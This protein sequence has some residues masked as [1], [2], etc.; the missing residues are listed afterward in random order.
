MYRAG[1]E[2]RWYVSL[3]C[4][5]TVLLLAGGVAALKEIRSR[6]AVQESAAREGMV[7]SVESL[8]LARMK[9]E[10]PQRRAAELD[11]IVAGP[12][13][14]TGAF[15][16]ERSHGIV[17][18]SGKV[19]PSWR[20]DF[21]KNVSWPQRG[22]H[23]A[24]PWRGLWG[25]VAWVSVGKGIVAGMALDEE[26]LNPE[27]AARIVLGFFVASGLLITI[28]VV[29]GGFF[30]L[31]HGRRMRELSEMKTDF[32]DSVTHELKTPLAGIR[33][34]I[35][36][37]SSPALKP[38]RAAVHRENIRR[39]TLRLIQLVDQ[40]LEVGRIEGK[41]RVYSPAPFDPVE[42]VRETVEPME[43]RFSANGI[44]VLDK[45]NARKMAWG[46]RDA[47]KAAFANILDNAAK[48][49]ASYGPVEVELAQDGGYWRISV[50]DRGPGMTAEE[51]SSCFDRM[52]RTKGAVASGAGG[53]GLGLDI[54]RG[55][56]RGMGGDIKV[57]PREGGGC[58]FDIFVKE[59]HNGEDPSG[60]E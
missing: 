50:K 60:G 6:L 2:L 28:S 10:G 26:A 45:A 24:V 58:I 27:G 53:S 19:D 21:P 44:A 42:L 34:A 4:L 17:R 59:A 38:E 20:S 52:Y 31:R 12:N 47:V 36:R 32:L 16:W 9:G 48:Y 8:A 25:N 39:E 51:M 37:L 29:L 33:F 56:M 43:G 15:L 3:I 49:A 30:L 14:V 57:R 54:A 5:P 11:S 22:S 18:E 40:L 35:E 1:R 23:H 41:R 13:H 7:K 55:S 46:D